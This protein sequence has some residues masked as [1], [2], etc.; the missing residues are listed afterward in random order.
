MNRWRLREGASMKHIQFPRRIRDNAF[1]SCLPH[2]P[3]DR[4][5]RPLGKTIAESNHK[6]RHAYGLAD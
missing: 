3:F 1:N 2:E 4:E 5:A 6:E